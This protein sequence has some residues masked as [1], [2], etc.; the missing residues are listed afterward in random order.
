M[1]MVSILQPNNEVERSD[2]QTIGV[3]TEMKREVLGKATSQTQ[4]K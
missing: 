2:L 4:N 1:P 3:H